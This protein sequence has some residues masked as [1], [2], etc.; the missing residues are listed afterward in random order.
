MLVTDR[1]GVIH[2]PFLLQFCGG[3]GG[4]DIKLSHLGTAP[5]TSRPCPCHHA[6]HCSAQALEQHSQ[7]P[8]PLGGESIQSRRVNLL[9]KRLNPA[10]TFPKLT[11]KCFLL[12]R[13]SEGTDSKGN[14][15]LDQGE[16]AF[17]AAER[18]VYPED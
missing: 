4:G 7:P 11:L 2:L 10:E 16:G 18:V 13:F 9:A 6:A 17:V 8:L 15:A 14:L 1:D 12:Y 3:S 5:C